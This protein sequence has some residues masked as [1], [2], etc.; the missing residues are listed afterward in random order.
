MIKIKQNILSV[1]LCVQLLGL[2]IFAYVHNNQIKGVNNQYQQSKF[3]QKA[4]LVDL[5]AEIRSLKSNLPGQANGATKL[6]QTI[7]RVVRQELSAYLASPSFQGISAQQAE[8]AYD[9]TDEDPAEILAQSIDPL[10]REQFVEEA[11]DLVKDAIING[12]W[13]NEDSQSIQELI[14]YLSSVERSEFLEDLGDAI[15]SQR[16]DIEGP[17]LF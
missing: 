5:L 4:I 17:I 14:P 12:Q 6:H 11:S 9:L 3:D 2:S 8:L 7:G 10:E 16:L 15:N 13:T 1:V